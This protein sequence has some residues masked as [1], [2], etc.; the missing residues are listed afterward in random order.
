MPRTQ[1]KAQAEHPEQGNRLRSACP[2]DHA[3]AEP[4]LGHELRLREQRPGG[5]RVCRSGEHGL[6]GANDAGRELTSAFP[7]AL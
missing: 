2:Q 5:V 6:V 1:H 7:G 3:A 4:Q